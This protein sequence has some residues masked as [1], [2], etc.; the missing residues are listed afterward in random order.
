V[1]CVDHRYA[2]YSEIDLYF[3]A[4]RTG[5]TRYMQFDPGLI[6]RREVQ[7]QMVRELE[8]RRPAAAVLS[9]RTFKVEANESSR[10][11]VSVLDDYLRSHYSVLGTT[12]PYR[13]LL[14]R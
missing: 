8:E 3:L 14:R 12:G 1:G 2:L 7:E 9:L 11:G 10:A 6:G 4:N 5:A 13:L